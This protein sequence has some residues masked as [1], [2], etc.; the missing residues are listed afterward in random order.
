MGIR[1]TQEKD[2]VL[3]FNGGF[4]S[5]FEGGRVK[6]GGEVFLTNEHYYAYT[7]ARFFYDFDTMRKI[8]AAE[9]PK[10]AKFLSRN[11]QGFKQPIWDSVKYRIMIRGLQSK[12]EYGTDNYNL[13]K[14]TKCKL[15]GEARPDMEWGIGLKI[16]D[17]NAFD[18]KNWKG[19]NLLGLA[20][21]T[22]RDGCDYVKIQQGS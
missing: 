10:V 6:V 7:K 11:V 9:T 18:Y 15:L 4:M 13:L 5:N 22:I 8:E 12:F 20:L 19:K 14:A 1:T 3:L 16:D 21:M 2:F 17:H